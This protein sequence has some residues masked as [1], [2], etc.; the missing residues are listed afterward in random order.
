[1]QI[2]LISDIK[3]F[4]FVFFFAFLPRVSSSCLSAPNCTALGRTACTGELPDVCGNCEEGLTGAS[5]P[6]NA[7]CVD[8]GAVCVGVWPGSATCGGGIRGKG[9]KIQTELKP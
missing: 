8:L 2:N 1:M 5:G 3:I 7:I 6:S 4:M 9:D